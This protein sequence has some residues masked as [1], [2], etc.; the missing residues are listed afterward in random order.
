MKAV[1]IILMVIGLIGVVVFGINAI[2]ETETFSLFGIDIAASRAD[3][4]PLALAG[5]VAL[6]GFGIFRAG[7]SKK[8]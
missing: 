3:Y 1:G 2:Q 6:I 5:I 8:A 7:K 4:T